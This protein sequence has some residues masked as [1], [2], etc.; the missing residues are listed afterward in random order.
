[1]GHLVEEEYL[2]RENIEDYFEAIAE[3]IKEA[4]MAFKQEL[5]NVLQ[6][7]GTGPIVEKTQKL[8]YYN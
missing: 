5:I 3:K 7:S 8:R 2:Y 1:M 6:H 4:E